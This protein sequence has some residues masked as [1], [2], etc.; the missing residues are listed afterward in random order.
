MDVFCEFPGVV[1]YS[2]LLVVV[3]YGLVGNACSLGE[4]AWISIEVEG[5]GQ[6]TA[7]L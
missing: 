4:K 5:A 6:K 3:V 7:L 1:Q 2:G